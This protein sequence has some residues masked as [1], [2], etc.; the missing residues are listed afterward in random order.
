[1]GAGEASVGKVEN[2]SGPPILYWALRAFF[3]VSPGQLVA[4]PVSGALPS[5]AVRVL[6]LQPW[7]ACAT[8]RR[9]ARELVQNPGGVEMADHGPMPPRSMK[10]DGAT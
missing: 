8:V 4:Q 7:R 5:A 1:V 2:A 10:E 3:P 9:G 6:A